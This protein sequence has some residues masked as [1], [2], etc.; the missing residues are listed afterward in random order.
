M[1][2]VLLPIAALLLAA[3]PAQAQNRPSQPEADS[4]WQI[5]GYLPPNQVM[6]VRTPPTGPD[7]RRRVEVLFLFSPAQAEGA[8]S[9]HNLYAVNCAAGTILDEGG[10]A[11][12]GARYLGRAA[13][14]TPSGFT[15]PVKDSIHAGI[16]AYGCGKARDLG[17]TWRRD[18]AIAAALAWM[19]TKQRK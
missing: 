7:D 10:T 9:M 2:A 1:R 12:L 18:D 6:L 8:D 4:E 5:L 13:S 3:V 16:T 19:K 14:E 11:W 15:K 17:E